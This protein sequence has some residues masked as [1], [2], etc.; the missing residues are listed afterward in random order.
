V[1]CIFRLEVFLNPDFSFSPP[2][3]LGLSITQTNVDASTNTVIL[4]V[5]TG[6]FAREVH[7]LACNFRALAV[8]NYVV[9]A[10]DSEMYSYCVKH[11]L[12]VFAAWLFKRDRVL[13]ASGNTKNTNKNTNKD[14]NNSTGKRANAHSSNTFSPE[15]R[16]H[17]A[18]QYG[19][20]HYNKITHC[21]VGCSIRLTFLSRSLSF[22]RFAPLSLSLHPLDQ[23]KTRVHQS[24]HI[25]THINEGTT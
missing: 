10:L 12:P 16:K 20:V 14:T 4:V 5:G 24:A 6:G 2:I 15:A 7:S 18:E 23:P 3:S 8:H 21:K 11:A 9:A 1:E 22:F 17:H 25:Q 13:S 19:T